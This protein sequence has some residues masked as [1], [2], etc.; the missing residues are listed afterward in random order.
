M[1]SVEFLW[2]IG[3]DN[4]THNSQ[5]TLGDWSKLERHALHA[6]VGVIAGMTVADTI[7]VTADRPYSLH[8]YVLLQI[9]VE[10]KTS[11]L[12]SGGCNVWCRV[13]EQYVAWYL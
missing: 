8:L 3:N 5:A 4:S 11:C 2:D 9:H 1:K 10:L 7:H 6:N 13:V 12:P